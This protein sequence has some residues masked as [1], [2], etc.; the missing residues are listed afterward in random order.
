MDIPNT[1]NLKDPAA[2]IV[3]TQEEFKWNKEIRYYSKTLISD[4]S[5]LPHL[6]NE[7]F[8]KFHLENV[9]HELKMLGYDDEFILDAECHTKISSLQIKFGIYDPH[10]IL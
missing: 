2:G 1:I 8:K 9:I 4:K 3:I 6:V 10:I 7:N 5:F